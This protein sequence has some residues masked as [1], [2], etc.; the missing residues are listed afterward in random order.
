[1]LGVNEDPRHHEVYYD[2]GENHGIV[3]V[4]GVDALE[5]SVHKGDRRETSL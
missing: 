3:L 1:M 2:G 5:I 4:D